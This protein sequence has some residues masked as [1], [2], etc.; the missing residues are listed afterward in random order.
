MLRRR[1]EAAFVH[2]D[3]SCDADLMHLKRLVVLAHR[4]PV[5]TLTVAMGGSTKQVSST[6]GVTSGMAGSFL[7]SS[8]PRFHQLQELFP[9]V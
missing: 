6:S 8:G 9:N 2:S 5:V 3:S 1:A 7:R 4:S